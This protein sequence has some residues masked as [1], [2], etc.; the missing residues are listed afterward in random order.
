M[1]QQG[2]NECL[3]LQEG[4]ESLPL[5]ELVGEA[6]QEKRQNWVDKVL[7]R[8]GA[9]PEQKYLLPPFGNESSLCWD[10]PDKVLQF[11]ETTECICKNNTNLENTSIL[12]INNISSCMPPS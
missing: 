8:T 9:R 4:R 5:K 3:K 12:F 6:C 1:S 2:V 11:P 7:D 10:A